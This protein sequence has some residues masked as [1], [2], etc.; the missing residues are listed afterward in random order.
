[1]LFVPLSVTNQVKLPLTTTSPAL[2][3]S[4][5][6]EEIS[7]TLSLDV[8]IMINDFEAPLTVTVSQEEN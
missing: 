7:F 5:G 1:M 4:S 8:S 2:N 3:V 6:I